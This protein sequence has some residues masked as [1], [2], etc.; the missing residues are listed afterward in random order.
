MFLGIDIGTSAVKLSLVSA[1]MVQVDQAQAPLTVSTPHPYWSEQNPEDWW[2][3]LATACRDLGARQDLSAVKAI[4]LSGQM[5]G[6]VLLDATGAVIR[7]SILWND[8]RSHGECGDLAEAVPEIGALS[9]V[10]PMPGFTAPKLLWLSRHE[11][12]AYARIARVLLPKDY[13]GWRLHGD[14]VTDRS[15]AAGTCWLDQAQ[16]SWSDLLCQASATDPVW[17][18]ALRDGT[19]FAG[20]L[21]KSAAAALDLPPGVPIA[22]GGGDAATGAVGIGAVRHGA[23]FLSLGTSGQLFVATDSYRPNPEQMVH[24]YCHTVPDMWF[25]MAAMLNGARPMQWFADI[26]GKALPDLLAEAAAVPPEDAP[27][28]LPYLTGERSPHGDPHI[29][30]AFYGLADGMGRAELMRGVVN[31]I[32]FSFKDAADSLRAA[33]TDVRHVL[34]IGGGAQSDLLLQTIADVLGT[35]IARSG[36]PTTGP[37]L[38][39]AKLAAVA[40]GTATLD[41]LAMRSTADRLFEPSGSDALEQGLKGFRLLYQRLRGIHEDLSGGRA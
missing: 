6:A 21:A 37:A 26:S 14:F 7:P 33:G 2:D 10:P 38:G 32:A 1:D 4:G 23:S 40:T 3:A 29:R 25:Q 8:G 15:D 17:L 35:P 41:D 12:E 13:V 30:G 22:A 39:A 18:P 16:R 19:E 11:P 34:A 24:A 36:D 20:T 5:H 9:G 27:L 31:A 28:Y